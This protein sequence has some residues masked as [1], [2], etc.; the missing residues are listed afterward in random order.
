M[1]ALSVNKTGSAESGAICPHFMMGNCRFGDKCKKSH[2][3][4]E[5]QQQAAAMYK[6]HMQNSSAEP[7]KRPPKEC[8]FYAQGKCLKGDTCS[9][10]HANHGQ[11][12]TEK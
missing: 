10:T 7:K 3:M 6:E 1:S 4:D 5:T 2:V 9:F 8:T 12:S 11:A